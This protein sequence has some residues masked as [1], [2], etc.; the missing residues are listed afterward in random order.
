MIASDVAEESPVRATIITLSHEE[1]SWE[2]T[3]REDL[4]TITLRKP[5][6]LGKKISRG[7]AAELKR[8]TPSLRNIGVEVTR[9]RENPRARKRLFI[10]EKKKDVNRPKRPIAHN[11]T[12]NGQNPR[13]ERTIKGR[14]PTIAASFDDHKPLL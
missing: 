10:I 9:R 12:G 7:L 2:G 6:R 11:P 13:S 5:G 3:A 8:L 1:P 14:Y 4:K